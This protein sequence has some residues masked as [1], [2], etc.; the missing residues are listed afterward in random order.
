MA[1]AETAPY[2][3]APRWRL[4]LLLTAWLVSTLL[5][6]AQQQHAH[7]ARPDLRVPFDVPVRTVG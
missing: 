4:A 5:L 7:A 3:D 2:S 6:L 1:I